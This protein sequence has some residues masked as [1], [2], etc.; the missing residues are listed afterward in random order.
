MITESP[1]KSPSG[2]PLYCPACRRELRMQSVTTSSKAKRRGGQPFQFRVAPCGCP[3][4]WYLQAGKVPRQG[5]HQTEQLA[6]AAWSGVMGTPVYS[7]PAAAAAQPAGA[8]RRVA[9]RGQSCPKC[10]SPVVLVDDGKTFVV[11]CGS[12]TVPC[13][14]TK[15]YTSAYTAQCSWDQWAASYNSVT[16]HSTH[17]KALIARQRHPLF[18][19]AKCR[20]PVDIVTANTPG[21]VTLYQCQCAN[22]PCMATNWEPSV[23]TAEGAWVRLFNGLP[24]TQRVK[25]PAQYPQPP[26]QM[27]FA[28]GTP[29]YTAVQ[30]DGANGVRPGLPGSALPGIGS[31]IRLMFQHNNEP[32]GG[33]AHVRVIDPTNPNNNAETSFKL[34]KKQIAGLVKDLGLWLS[35][36]IWGADD[37]PT[38][39]EI[40]AAQE[41]L[42]QRLEAALPSPLAMRATWRT[43]TEQ[44]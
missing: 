12:T 27:Q 4:P 38:P 32:G 36:P 3:A 29:I 14:I 37:D 16:P 43:K 18:Y 28:S 19:C 5:W 13:H 20:G 11:A 15:Q 31:P 41:K 9:I 33:L 21:A 17:A 22:G 10:H 34:D 1:C 7:A 6:L 44:S 25:P 8:L 40:A 2:L 26:V 23:A 39:E 42:A 30:A 24:P 35:L